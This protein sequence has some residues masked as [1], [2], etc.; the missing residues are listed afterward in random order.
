MKIVINTCA[1]GFGLSNQAYAWLIDKGIPVSP[2]AVGYCTET[3]IIFKPVTPILWLGEYYDTYFK[4]NRSHPLLVEVVETLKDKVSGRLAALKIIEIPDG[5]EY[6]IEQT[7][8]IEWVTEKHRT[9][10]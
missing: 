6:T 7:H 8:G 10:S 3:P 1:G 5:I 4:Y 2:D 9:W